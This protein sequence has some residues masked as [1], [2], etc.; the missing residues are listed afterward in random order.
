MTYS[1]KVFNLSRMVDPSKIMLLSITIWAR[2]R[3]RNIHFTLF[4]SNTQAVCP[5]HTKYG[6]DHLETLMTKTF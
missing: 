3:I 2:I 1:F 4:L 5:V 6:T